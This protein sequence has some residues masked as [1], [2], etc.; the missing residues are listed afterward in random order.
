[1]RGFEA[2]ND[3]GVKLMF[4]VD[5]LNEGVHVPRVSAVLM[6]RTTSS[7]IIY[8]Q[9]MGRCLTAANTEK[10]LVLDMVD[11]ITTTTAIKGL[12]DEFEQMEAIQAE[13]EHREP[14]KFEVID[15]T[16]GVKKLIDKLVPHDV[17]Y[18]GAEER[19]AIV[20]PFSDEKKR[21]PSHS[22]EPEIY[23][24]WS[25]LLSHAKDHPEVQRLFRT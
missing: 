7:R 12:Q 23:K 19:L 16:I 1:M 22:L 8:M 20:V 18:W 6:L 24:H 9:Q 11:N 25:W 21:L 4:C 2:D 13:H 14:R 10:P 17:C 3:S 15:Y 5:M